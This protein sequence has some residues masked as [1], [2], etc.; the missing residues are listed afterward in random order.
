MIT[1]LCRCICTPLP[2]Y[3]HSFMPLHMWMHSHCYLPSNSAN[4]SPFSILFVSLFETWGYGLLHMHGRTVPNCWHIIPG[5]LEASLL[6][7]RLISS[8][9]I[10][11]LA[12]TIPKEEYLIQEI[13]PELA[14]CIFVT[15]FGVKF[16]QSVKKC[17]SSLA[18]MPL[19][20]QFLLL[21]H[22]SFT[23]IPLTTVVS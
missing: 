17:T 22:Y 4:A 9:V 20:F 18:T 13:G 12:I 11:H 10:D 7:V 2:I 3:C 19:Q 21:Y 16:P 14:M 15:F 5:M 6:W 1:W 8:I 23:T